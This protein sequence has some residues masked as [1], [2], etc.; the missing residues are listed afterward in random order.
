MKRLISAFVMIL[1]ATFLSGCIETQKGEKIGMITKVAQEGFFCPTWEAQVIRGGFNQG[2]GASGTAFEFTIESDE[3]A[4][5]V[6]KLAE[7]RKEV[8]ITYRKEAMTICS[9]D[10]N[11]Y[12]L[13]SIEEL[14][15]GEQGKGS[16]IEPAVVAAPN[17]VVAATAATGQ[18]R[19][20]IVRLLK[21]QAELI[22]ELAKDVK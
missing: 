8:K 10:S 4:Q 6:T 2:S 15:H 16:V 12:F 18:D 14:K 9:S 5:K 1:T 13:V 7:E 20:K 11:N 3:M 17:A 21:V 22:A 19:E